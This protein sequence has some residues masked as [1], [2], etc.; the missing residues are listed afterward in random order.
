[1]RVEKMGKTLD[2]KE[3]TY[4]LLKHSPGE[5][6]YEIASDEAVYPY[7]VFAFDNINLGDLCRDDIML[8]VDVWSNDVREANSVADAIEKDLN[9]INAS[10]E[11][12]ILHFSEIAGR[13]YRM[14]TN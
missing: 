4:D 6:Y 5:A 1:M 11:H 12:L 9:G 13:R 8:I 3:I 2:L 10:M 14:R 7:K